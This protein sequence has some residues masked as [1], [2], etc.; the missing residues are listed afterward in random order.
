MIGLLATTN[1][2]LT[3]EMSNGGHCV[4]SYH[5]RN[6]RKMP[7]GAVV[8]ARLTTVSY[9]HTMHNVHQDVTTEEVVPVSSH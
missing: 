4:G 2:Y 3:A 9:C 8:M 5:V 7:A 6:L 1:V